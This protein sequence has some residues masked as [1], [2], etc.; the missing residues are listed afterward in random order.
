MKETQRAKVIVGAF[1]A[2]AI[3]VFA[4]L[5]VSLG[6]V[7]L[8]SKIR[9]SALF[10][11]VTG[12]VPGARVM[13]AG[14]PVGQVRELEVEGGRARVRFVLY[15]GHGVTQG[16]TAAV[17]SRSLLGEKYLAVLPAAAPGPP[18]GEPFELPA[19]PVP[20]SID[21]VLARVGPAIE[22]IPFDALAS[23]LE[24]V[25]RFLK[26][27]LPK[28]DRL[29][30]QADL[31]QVTAAA[32]SL[33]EILDAERP[34][35]HETL[36]ATRDLAK[37][38]G[39]G[40]ARNAEELRLLLAN[41]RRSSEI[42]AKLDEGA[43]TADAERVRA[44]LDRLPATLDRLDAALAVLV[45]LEPL[46]DRLQELDGDDVERVLQRE[47]VRIRFSEKP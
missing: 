28:L 16:A 47:G 25:D 39:P 15:A 10:D 21:D 41:L 13:V 4:F 45:K 46:V 30:E 27:T 18:I 3:G 23:D 33:R 12:L 26:E 6:D 9:G 7:S 35:I 20:P 38:Y 31:S 43:V 44:A 8:R 22:R 24:Q 37:A 17:R 42:L 2:A 29:V 40:A 32:R 1:T 5:V 14:V 11:D 36:A 19:E 34:A